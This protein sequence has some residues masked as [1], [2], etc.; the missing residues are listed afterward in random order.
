[1]LNFIAVLTALGAG[2]AF[3][4]ANAARS[5]A[6]YLFASLLPEQN[7]PDYH[8]E[9]GTMTVR[10]TM[11]GLVGMDSPYPP[12]GLVEASS[13]E[14][15]TLKIA[16]YARLNEATLRQLQFLIQQLQISGGNTSEA[17][18][19]TVLN[20]LQKVIV[21]PHLDTAEWLRSRALF[22][23]AIDWTF[24]SINVQVDY[25][26]P[27]GNFLA[28]R[29][30]TA[31]WDGADSAFWADMRALRRLLK[32]NVRAFILNGITADAI[33]YN[34]ANGMVPITEGGSGAIRTVTFRR[35]ARDSAGVFDPRAFS[36]DAQ[37][38]VQ[39]IIYDGEAEIINPAAPNETIVL[40]FVPTGKILAVGNNTASGFVVG[41]GSSPDPNEA[42][43]LG[44]TH[45]GPT[46]EGGGAPGRWADLF[47][48]QHEPW[49]LHGRGVT[50]LLPVIEAPRKLAVATSTI[51]DAEAES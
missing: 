43:N 35:F 3:R 38:T 32:N 1:M 31:A 41:Q 48:P 28:A 10:S 18:S 33:R 4:I 7:R 17:M 34:P 39:F 42:N 37:E 47:T 29:S 16:N 20:F 24:N 40:P 19:Q 21:Q 15:K 44:Y 8:I 51:T 9:A 30:G 13:F 45:I 22:N 50:N 2:A 23:G 27:A 5:G 6:E 49:S 14:E 36:P 12:T 46:V 11:A 25:G 26:V